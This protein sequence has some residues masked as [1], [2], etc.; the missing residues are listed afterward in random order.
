MVTFS[1]AF[2]NNFERGLVT[3]GVGAHPVH[4]RMRC[5]PGKRRLEILLAPAAGRRYPNL[6]DHRRNLEYDVKRIAHRLGHQAFVPCPP[7]A[8]G[9]WVVIPFSFRP[10]HKTGVVV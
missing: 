9:Q 7:R 5:V 10:G 1:R 3:D 6:A 2:V 4:A 8:E